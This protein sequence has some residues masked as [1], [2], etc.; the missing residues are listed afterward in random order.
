LIKNGYLKKDGLLDLADCLM[1]GFKR[2]RSDPRTA[3]KLYNQAANLSQP[4]AMCSYAIIIYQSIL[5]KWSIQ[6]P[7]PIPAGKI[8]EIDMG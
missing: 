1:Y 8:N 4:E 2:Q 5:L 3:S 6:F 7:A